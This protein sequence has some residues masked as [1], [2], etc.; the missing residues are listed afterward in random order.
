M[1]PPLARGRR[2]R[3]VRCRSLRG[4]SS[5]RGRDGGYRIFPRDR[6]DAVVDAL[7]QH[8]Y[9]CRRD[10]SLVNRASGVTEA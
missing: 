1:G 5:L 6:T 9:A 7:Q 10:D 8:G 4:L 2:H 3:A